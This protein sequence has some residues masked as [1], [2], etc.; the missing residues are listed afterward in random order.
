MLRAI[1]ILALLSAICAAGTPAKPP[2]SPA[3]PE[4]PA[5]ALIEAGKEMFDEFAPDEV[6][7]QYEF[8]SKEQFDQFA[9]RLQGALDREDL[10]ELV[11]YEPEARAALAALRAIPECEDY[12]DWLAVRLDYIE[13]AKLAA[14]TPPRPVPPMGTTPKS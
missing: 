9:A 7:E 10:G 1:V 12:A 8:P 6:K 4:T 14:G 3:K 5:D 13:A 11:K 2:Q